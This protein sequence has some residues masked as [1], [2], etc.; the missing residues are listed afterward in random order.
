MTDHHAVG[1]DDRR[2]PDRRVRFAWPEVD[3]RHADERR[4]GDD[5]SARDA[6]RDLYLLV[7]SMDSVTSDD[8]YEAVMSRVALILRI[9]RYSRPKK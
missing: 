3:R 9:P 7:E 4:K 2:T 5:H 1:S 6:L 8:A